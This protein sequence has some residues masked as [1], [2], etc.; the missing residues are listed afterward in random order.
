MINPIAMKRKLFLVL[1]ALCLAGLSQ[2]QND[3]DALRYAML[4]FGSTA[5]ASGAGGAFGAV[6][7][8]F[9]GASIN[10]AGLGVY[11]GS[12]FQFSPGFSYTGS[13]TDS[14]VSLG[15]SVRANANIGSMSLVFTDL[16]DRY[17]YG[18]GMRRASTTFAIGV[19]RLASFSSGREF[20]GF[21]T[22]NSLLDSYT[23]FLNS[24]FGTPPDEA[25]NA[26]PFG[27]G[28]AYN[29]Y[30][31]NPIPGDS[32]RYFNVV[33]D[34]NVEQSRQLTSRGSV[35]EMLIGMGVNLGHKVYFG[36]S[37][38]IPFLKYVEEAVY[39]E[40]DSEGNIPGFSSFTQRNLLDTR[41]TGLNAKLGIIV[42]PVE[43]LRLGAA[44]HSPTRYRLTDEFTSQINSDI[45]TNSYEEFSPFGLFNYTLRSPWRA[46]GS[47]TVLI[48][49]YG[50]LSFDYEYM[51]YGFSAFD[52]SRGGLGFES[53]EAEL[54][55]QI[56]G[57]YTRAH[58][59]RGGA[60]AVSGPMRFR[61]GYS[62]LGT[63]FADFRAPADAD[64]SRHSF[65]GGLG[66]RGEHV[67]VDLSYVHSLSTFGDVPYQLADESEPIPFA[68][69]EQTMGTAV[70]S[71]GVRF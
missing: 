70:L 20:S 13:S 62:Y 23:E 59:L 54:N 4:Q 61:A 3:A 28:L 36:G 15:N 51:D 68:R 16:N 44:I 58:N 6:G 26:D 37:V 30:L 50:F 49:E 52:F 57:K 21:N 17:R 24:G 60:E 7:A 25:F 43:A 5:R 53:E 2:A 56:S 11:R 33:P 9:G 64:L 45:E 67:F 46:I 34:G 66:Y 38:G 19:N 22:D 39:T 65:H 1:T 18:S 69:T 48:K 14:F 27:A 10:P 42:R 12:E 31:L 71:M 40:R 55:T 8:D 32:L 47:A 41:G 29:A 35:S 63:P